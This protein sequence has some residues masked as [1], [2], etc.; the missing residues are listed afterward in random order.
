MISKC[1]RFAKQLRRHEPRVDAVH[2]RAGAD[3]AQR[4][5]AEQ[6]PPVAWAVGKGCQGEGC[7]HEE[8]PEG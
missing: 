8:G 7:R 3:P 4:G 2:E 6:L 1:L 5:G